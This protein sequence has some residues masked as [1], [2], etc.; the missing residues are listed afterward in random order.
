MLTVVSILLEQFICVMLNVWISA[1]MEQWKSVF[2]QQMGNIIDCFSFVPSIANDTKDLG[3]ILFL[4]RS[5]I[6]EK[7]SKFMHVEIF[8]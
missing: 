2:Y 7:K 6:F 1:C 4:I 3:K 8:C 5:V